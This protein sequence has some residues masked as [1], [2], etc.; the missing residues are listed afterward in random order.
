MSISEQ[1]VLEI[2]KQILIINPI[3]ANYWEYYSKITPEDI[4]NDICEY[5]DYLDEIHAK[6]NLLKVIRKCLIDEFPI[7]EYGVFDTELG[8]TFVNINDYEKF[9]HNKEYHIRTIL[10][11][12]LKDDNLAIPFSLDGSIKYQKCFDALEYQ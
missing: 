1:K 8:Q 4:K 2:A 9:T 11:Y 10:F 12:Y 5:G 7:L 3:K 6:E